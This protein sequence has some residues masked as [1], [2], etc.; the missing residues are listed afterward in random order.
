[1]QSIR[2]GDAR[3][4]ARGVAV[5]LLFAGRRAPAATPGRPDR[6]DTGVRRRRCDRRASRPP[7]PSRRPR[8]FRGIVDEP[9]VAAHDIAA[10]VAELGITDTAGPACSDD[11]DCDGDSCREH[12]DGH[13]PAGRR[14]RVD[15]RDADQGRAQPG[16]VAGRVDAGTF[17]PDLTE[18]TTFVRASHACRRA[19]R[20]STAT[21]SRSPRSGRSCG[22]ASCRARSTRGPTPPYRAAA[23]RLRRAARPGQGGA[24]R[25]VRAGHRP[26]AR[27]TTSRCATRCSRSPASRSTR[28]TGRWRRRPSGA[29]PCSALSVRPPRTRWRTPARWPCRPTRSALSGLQFAYQEQLAGTPGVTIDLVE[30]ASDDVHQQV[31]SSARR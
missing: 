27:P 3:A 22:S 15:L 23:D 8:H 18:V 31:L 20:S 24:A 21:A 4:C 11:L 16:P 1:M 14:R 26:P 29:G 28:P 13:A 7:G 25:L 6:R 9:A 12:A 2:S 30:K 5:A 17:H 10:H 19:L